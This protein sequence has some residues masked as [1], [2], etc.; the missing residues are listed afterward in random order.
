MY[1][2]SELVVLCVTLQNMCVPIYID[3]VSQLLMEVSPSPYICKICE[4]LYKKQ[5]K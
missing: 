1:L 2:V 3:T 4:H 5:Q